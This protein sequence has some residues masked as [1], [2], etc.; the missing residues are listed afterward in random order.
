VV[1]RISRARR[2]RRQAG[3]F[4]VALLGA[5]AV[6]GTLAPAALGAPAPKVFWSNQTS[7]TIGSANLDGGEADQAFISVAGVPDGV[8]VDGQHVYWANRTSGT[9]GRANLDGTGID[10]SFISTAENPGGL[11]VTGEHIYWLNLVAGSIGRANLDGT[12]VNQSFITGLAQPAG[13]AVAGQHIYWV[14]QGANQSVGRANLDG[15]GIDPTFITGAEGPTAVAVDGR[16]VYWTN[17]TTGSIGRANMDGSGV[18][19]SFVTGIDE[20][21]G[22]AVEGRL[23]WTSDATGAIGDA[24]L[25]GGEV[26]QEL[27]GGIAGVAA[28]ALSPVA[29]ASTSQPSLPSFAIT[30]LGTLSLPQTVTLS[31]AGLAPLSLTGLSFVGTDPA[32]F[33]VGSNGCLGEVGPGESCQLTVS[34]AP[35]GQGERAASLQ[36]AGNDPFGPLELAVSGTGGSLPTGLS[37]A[38]GAAGAASAGPPG[39]AGPAGETHLIKCRT[40]V[41]VTTKK[42]KGKPH[43]VRHKRQKCTQVS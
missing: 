43:K 23:F 36:I 11:A 3:P 31:N 7:E 5:A 15:G 25:E 16:H 27:I 4:L 8:A 39:P 34:F 1:G 6:L 29:L 17:N 38:P 40:V 22:V 10:Q 37:G 13:L 28:V 42:V 41:T 14:E 18:D 35:Q 21:V 9:I 2:A 26:S 32:D 20:P 12:G 33:L 30:P 24:N 19:Q